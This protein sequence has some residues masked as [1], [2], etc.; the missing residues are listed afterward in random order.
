MISRP[1][2]LDACMV[3]CVGAL[4]L[5]GACSDQ[6]P[7]SASRTGEA[8]VGS[9]ASASGNG[10]GGGGSEDAR[11]AASEG[12]SSPASA[13]VPARPAYAPL[14]PAARVQREQSEGGTETLTLVTSDSP[15]AVIEFY[16]RSVEEAGLDVAAVLSQGDTRVLG[17]REAERGIEVLVMARPTD[18]GTVVD[19]AWSDA[20]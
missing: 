1:F 15:E 10:A 9:P 3:V 16:R 2:S 11:D 20:E 18:E 14:Y 12:T 4:A 19:L 17:A 6:A 5:L 8:P 7:D 13:S